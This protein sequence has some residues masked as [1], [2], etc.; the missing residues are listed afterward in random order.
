MEILS[1]IH[2]SLSSRRLVLRLHF[3]D[4]N[5]VLHLPIMKGKPACSTIYSMVLYTA[6]LVEISCR[7]GMRRL[8]ELTKTALL[9]ISGSQLIMRVI[10]V[11]PYNRLS[12]NACTSHKIEARDLYNFVLKDI[13]ELAAMA[14]KNADTFYQWLSSPPVYG[15]RFR[16]AERP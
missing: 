1:H 2:K 7:C 9:A 6:P 4:G 11:R 3:A 15:G 12:K 14:L 5:L 10:F 13:Q 16:N 8:E